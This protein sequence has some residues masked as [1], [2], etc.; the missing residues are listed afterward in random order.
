M[1]RQIKNLVVDELRKRYGNVDSALV[2]RVIGLDAVSNN[3]LRRRLHGKKIELH[4]IKNSLA[5]VAFKGKALEPLANALEGPS[6][7]VT[8]GDSIIDV[9]KELVAI[10]RDKQF[11]KIE[12]LFGEIEGDRE[13]V[14]VVRIAEMKGRREMHADVL[15]CAI[16]PARKLV[17]CMAGAGGRIAGCLKAIVEKGEKA[18]AEAAPAPE[19]APVA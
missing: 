5:R 4:V 14:P 2:V 10:A 12:L 19:A 7:V 8:G 15:G 13:V 11:A 6:A 16:G 18:P 17:G 9:A 3:N 1:S